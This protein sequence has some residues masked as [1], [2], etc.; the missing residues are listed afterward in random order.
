MGFFQLGSMFV[1]AITFLFADFNKL[2][3]AWLI[4]LCWFVSF[5]LVGK[6]IGQLIGGILGFAR[7]R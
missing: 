4:P 5:T 3:L 2:N 1:L 7:K 6:E